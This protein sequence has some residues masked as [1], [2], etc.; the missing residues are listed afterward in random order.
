MYTLPLAS[1]TAVDAVRRRFAPD[2]AP[3]RALEQARP[4][5]WRLMLAATL[6][7]AARAV[8]PAGRVPAH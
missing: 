4:I 1:T 8:A 2:V 5:R 6:E 7:R 3:R